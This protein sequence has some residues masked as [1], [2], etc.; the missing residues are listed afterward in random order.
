MA[1]KNQVE[2][3]FVGYQVISLRIDD[4]S[5][6]DLRKQLND[7]GWTTI[8]TDDGEV[9]LDLNKVAFIKVAA[10]SSSVGFQS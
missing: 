4:G 5:L 3:G 10:K 1:E 9:D 2:V 6:K 8:V 7:G